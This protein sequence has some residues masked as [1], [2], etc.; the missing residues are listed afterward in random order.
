MKKTYKKPMMIVEW[1]ALS[2]TIATGCGDLSSYGSPTL[3][4]IAN[5]AWDF[6]GDYLL[7][8]EGNNNCEYPIEDGTIDGLC[9]N[10][11][12]EGLNLFHS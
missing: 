10:T 9:Y 5:C 12:S 4:R 6:N 1:F 7:F 11:P 8:L 3:T 2:Q